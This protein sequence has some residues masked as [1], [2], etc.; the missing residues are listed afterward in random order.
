MRVRLVH[1]VVAQ[2]Y[3]RRAQNLRTIQI[4]AQ[5]ELVNGAIFVAIMVNHS[6]IDEIGCFGERK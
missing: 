4:L 3:L 5:L 6:L 1:I 2:I